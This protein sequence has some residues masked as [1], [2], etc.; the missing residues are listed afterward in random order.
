MRKKQHSKDRMSITKT[1]W[2][3][4]KSKKKNRTPF[5]RLPFYCCA[6]ASLFIPILTFTPF[7][8]P[9]CTKDGSVFDLMNIIP[10]ITKH[11]KN[12]VTGVPLKQ[13][14]LI[15]LT[16]HKNSEGTRD[17]HDAHLYRHLV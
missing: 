1:K 15:S 17:P 4:A 11:E 2:G 16:F 12:L 7:G 9:V 13:D 8:L 10:Y 14:D 3:G 5:K 6:Y